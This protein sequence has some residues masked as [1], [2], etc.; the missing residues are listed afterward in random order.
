MKVNPGDE[1]H[2][3]QCERAHEEKRSDRREANRLIREAIRKQKVAQ[4]GK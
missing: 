3:Y 4:G 2:V 1:R